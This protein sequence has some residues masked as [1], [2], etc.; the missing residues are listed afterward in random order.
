M[1]INLSTKVIDADFQVYSLFPGEGYKHRHVMI[2]K[3]FVYLD[4]PEIEIPP[5]AVEMQSRDFLLRVA[6]SEEF[7]YW[8][9]RRRPVGERP[10]DNLNDYDG[11]RSGQRRSRY[12]NALSGLIFEAKKSELVLVPDMGAFGDLLVGEFVEDPGVIRYVQVGPMET[13]YVGRRVRWLTRISQHTLSSEFLKSVRTPNP[14]VIVERSY[15]KRIYE[16]AYTSF[17][18]NGEISARFDVRGLS[19]TS[20]D[21]FHF[22]RFVNYVSALC[23]EA[24]EKDGIDPDIFEA[25]S[26]IAD[27]SFLPDLTLNINSPGFIALISGKVTP[28]VV[29]GLFALALA[30]CVPGA[31]ILPVDVNNLTVALLN[32]P[33]DPCAIEVSES[34]KYS[35]DIM[36][37]ENW[38]K[39]CRSAM[40]LKEDAEMIPPATVRE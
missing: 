26:L 15:R 23:E 32:N 5:T 29:A 10:S 18:M 34:I 8:I 20:G 3:N 13:R 11:V 36:G 37:Y 14:L 25:I 28:L 7:A 22:A 6:Q 30:S 27:D 9:S 24:V 2:E 16:A 38:Q 19:F 40:K 17:V 1:Q 33:D 4:F 12:I 39:L 31:E 21:D 35:L